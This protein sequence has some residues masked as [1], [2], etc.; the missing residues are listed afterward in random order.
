MR[1]TRTIRSSLAL[2]AVLALGAC[3]GLSERQTDTAIGA[4]VGGVAGS[5]V[6]GGSTLGTV[7]WAV[8]GGAVG[9]EAGER[10]RE[11]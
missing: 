1:P 6:T 5:A 11:R 8:L 7:G 10:I 3:S 9:P 4:T 2:A